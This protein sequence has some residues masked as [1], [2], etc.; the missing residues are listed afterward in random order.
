MSERH[1][2]SR[3]IM[4]ALC[5]TLAGCASY[6]GAPEPATPAADA[7]VDAAADSA[8]AADAAQRTDP[9]PTRPDARGGEGQQEVIA[10]RTDPGPT[11]PPFRA[12]IDRREPEPIEAGVAPQ[13]G[14]YFFPQF[15]I[16]SYDVELA[17]SDTSKVI[18]GFVRIAF[19]IPKPDSVAV[20]GADAV[21]HTLSLDFTGLAMLGAM[22]DGEEQQSA[23]S[24]G[25]LLIPVLGYGRHT[26]EILYSGTPDDGLIIQDNVH[27]EPTVFADNWPNR[28]RFWFPSVDHPA[29]KAALSFT[30]HAPERWEVISNGALAAEPSPAAADAL[31]GAEGKR[32]WRWQSDVPHPVYTMVVGAAAFEILPLGLAACGH[33]PASQ[34]EDGCVEVS[35]WVFAP[36][37][38]FAAQVFGR[39][40]EMTDYYTEL[41]GDFPYE[42]LANVQSST[43]FGGMENSSAIFYSEGAIAESR[44]SETTVAHEIVHQWFGDSATEADWNHLWLSEGFATY[45]AYQFFL[46][47]D[48]EEAFETRLEGARQG[49]LGSDAS[50]RPII[51]P[52]ETNLY[53]LLNSNNYPKGGWV[54]HMLRGMLGDEAFFR[55]VRTYYERHANSTALTA[56]FQSVLQE[57]SGEDL[58]WYFEQWV[59]RPGFPRFSVDWI[60]DEGTGQGKI[61]VTQTQSADWPT[62]RMPAEIEIQIGATSQ[63]LDVEI[64]ERVHTFEFSSPVRPT[65]VVLDPD[66]WI[67]KEIAGEG[68]D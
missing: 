68:E 49:V 43:R 62:F 54:L 21:A 7:A 38:A 52:E 17:L 46:H 53:R 63:R 31:G 60:W 58:G 51:D 10:R 33:A 3:L 27:G 35:A 15:D 37:T 12:I 1:L 14:E 25:K 26:A 50:Q 65:D 11:R 40:A 55:G 39:A 29:D 2:P 44:L 42:K 57:V 47:A 19:D 24:P 59:M 13:A 41:F 32:T 61:E 34:R 66:G 4:T 6:G 22:M 5:L 56:D 67:L 16:L 36:D 8:A 48:G 45:F 30:V 23:T 64:S 20:A 9:A 18:D 28:A